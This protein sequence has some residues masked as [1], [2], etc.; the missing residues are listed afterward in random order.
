MTKYITEDGEIRDTTCDECTYYFKTPN[1]H[2]T[3]NEAYLS[4]LECKDP[5]KTDQSFKD[6]ADINQIIDRL[7]RGQQ[8]NIPLPEDFGTDDR[9]TYLEMQERINESKATFYNL[10][11]EIRSEFMN[12]H[13]RWADQV[14]R[15][16]ARGNIENLNRM[17]IAVEKPPEPLP[18]PISSPGTATGGGGPVS[19]PEPPKND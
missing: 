16:L 13:T 12:D 4:A 2:D 7:K 5:S 14:T 9:M 11:P 19:P 10:A 8:V 18:E 1:N 17:G 15:D 6:D 3:L